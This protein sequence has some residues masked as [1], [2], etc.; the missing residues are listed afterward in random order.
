[1]SRAVATVPT[2]REFV[3]GL[4]TR[5]LGGSQAPFAEYAH[6]PADF[7]LE[8]LGVPFLTPEQI[9]ICEQVRDRREINVQ[10]GNGVGKTFVMA[11]LVLW[12]V[13]ARGGLAITT[14]PT[15]RQVRELLWREVRQLY[16]QNRGTLGGRRRGLMRIELSERMAA[17]GFTASQHQEEGF[18]GIH[19]E[20]LL[21]IEDEASGIT[22]VID[23]GFDSCLT[24]A[25]NKGCRIGNPLAAGTPFFYACTTHGSIR[26]PVWTH[27]NVSW[28]YDPDTGDMAR[29]VAKAIMEVDARGRPAVRE[30]EEWPEWC[31]R[32]DPIP[33]AVSVEWIEK[34]RA[35]PRRGPGTGYWEAR[36]W[37]RFPEDVAN[38]IV[39]RAWF[40]DARNR[41]DEDPA[42]WDARAMQHPWVHGL[43]VGDGVDPHALVQRRGPVIYIAQLMPSIGDQEDT[44]RATGW[45]LEE[46]RTK[47]GRGYVDRTGVGANVNASLRQTKRAK[48]A[49]WTVTGVSF[50]GKPLTRRRKGPRDDDE[51]PEF[52]NRKGE[53]YY[54]LR[55]GIRSGRTAIAPLG[56]LEEQLKEDLARTQFF[57][58]STGKVQ[59]E[60]KETVRK[61]LGR[62]TDLGDA[63]A[64]TVEIPR[65]EE[66]PGY[67]HE[68][69]FEGGLYV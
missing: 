18:Q 15:Q 8:V 40:E 16:D 32:E 46:L 35:D 64:L 55:E 22:D 33:G 20:N 49:E 1:M 5:L 48:Q 61:R 62:S 36:L 43:D 57:H 6:R 54:H 14:A 31:Q 58:T 23:D 51:V 50:G 41:Y 7:I 34:A 24:A 3:M 11:C 68:E 17:W 44:A 66:A 38:A 37:A 29:D 26:I 30:R 12:W 39:P 60:A 47:G 21:A 59:I 9:R 19:E 45:L 25:T 2:G 52:L 27:P 13:F 56:P 63:A 67:F 65:P 69:V 42:G 10:A 28:A 53:L 4:V